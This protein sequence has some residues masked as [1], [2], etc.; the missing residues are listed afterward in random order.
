MVS[1]ITEEQAFRRRNPD[2]SHEG[3]APKPQMLEAAAEAAGH[4]FGRELSDPEKAAE[5]V[6]LA[7]R[8]ARPLSVQDE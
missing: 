6:F 1:E 2:Q 4:F 3:L 7:M 5:A 8:A